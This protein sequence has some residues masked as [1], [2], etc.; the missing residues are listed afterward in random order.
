MSDLQMLKSQIE[1]L[2]PEEITELREFMD[3]TQRI[4]PSAQK[5]PELRLSALREAL[6]KFREGI[7]DAEMKRIAEVINIKR[8]DWNRWQQGGQS[9]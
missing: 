9:E 6:D 7:S 4:R 2:D 1:R 8:E 3:S 5:D